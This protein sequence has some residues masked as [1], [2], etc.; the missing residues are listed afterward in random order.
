MKL[1]D[2][3][4]FQVAGSPPA[5]NVQL[6]NMTAP[7]VKQRD[8]KLM[9]LEQQVNKSMHDAIAKLEPIKPEKFSQPS[10]K[11]RMVSYEDAIKELAN[12]LKS[13][14]NKP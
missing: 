1:R 4:G 2:V 14:D 7:F 12:S 9:K 10:N 3:Y 8:E 5:M 6:P 11:V 13:T